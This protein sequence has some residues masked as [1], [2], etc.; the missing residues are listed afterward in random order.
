[1]RATSASSS[2][3]PTLSGITISPSRMTGNSPTRSGSVASSGRYAARSRPFSSSRRRR[4]PRPC[5]SDSMKARARRPPQRG[6]KTCSS[7]SKAASTGLGIIGRIDRGSRATSPV[8]LSESWSDTRPY[9]AL[10][11]GNLSVL[12]GDEV[13]NADRRADV[14]V[15]DLARRQDDLHRCG[16]LIR[17]QAQDVGDAVEPCPLL[18]IR[19]DDP[20]GGLGRVGGVEHRVLGLGVLDPLGAGRDVHGRDLPAL[21][22]VLDPILEAALLLLIADREPELD[23]DDS[24]ADQ[25]PLE[26]GRRP[27]ELLVFGLGAEAH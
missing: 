4:G 11:G 27:K 19:F 20:P 22:R 24:G 14:A 2:M 26:L 12:L 10:R 15:V 21:G 13:L 5:R 25:H 3:R 16:V 9:Y 17:D 23:E 1:M 18:V 8:R 6:S 7:E